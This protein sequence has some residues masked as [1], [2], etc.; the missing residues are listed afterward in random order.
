M[1]N[2]RMSLEDR[3][4]VRIIIVDMWMR[5]ERQGNYENEETRGKG[6]SVLSS[7]KTR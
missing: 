5:N 2:C 7:G 4:R 6:L 1:I 3:E